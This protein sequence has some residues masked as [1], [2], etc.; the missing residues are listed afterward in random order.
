MKGVRSLVH[1]DAFRPDGALEHQQAASPRRALGWG[2]RFSRADGLFSML[3]L[4]SS[5]GSVRL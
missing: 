3:I 1:S 4:F 2:A 5:S